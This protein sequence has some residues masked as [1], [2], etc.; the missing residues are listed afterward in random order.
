MND[1]NFFVFRLRGIRVMG[2]LNAFLSSDNRKMEYAHFEQITKLLDPGDQM[3][4]VFS[5]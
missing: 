5:A 3:T 2:P 4:P 1:I